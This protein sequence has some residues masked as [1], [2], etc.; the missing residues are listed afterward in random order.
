[1]NVDPAELVRAEIAFL[2]G[3]SE[4]L[5]RRAAELRDLLKDGRDEGLISKLEALP[6]VAAKSGKCDFLRDAPAELVA[7]I[8]SSKNGIRG[9]DRH[10]TASSTEPTL[11]RFP[12]RKEAKSA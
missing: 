7:A 3:R 2:E 1:L 5:R 12:R 9:P 6:W 8:R 11:F 10:Y 4:E